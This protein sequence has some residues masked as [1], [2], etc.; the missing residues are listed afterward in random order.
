MGVNW[1]GFA[2][3]QCINIEIEPGVDGPG[4]W[5]DPY[6]SSASFDECR[7]ANL[8]PKTQSRGSRD[9]PSL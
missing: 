3:D 7:V 2:V 5:F 4:A 8:L 1:R 6:Q 9:R